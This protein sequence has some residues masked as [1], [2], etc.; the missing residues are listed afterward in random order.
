MNIPLLRSTFDVVRQDTET[1][2]RA[3]YGRLFAV[4]PQVSPLFKDTDFDSQ[5]KK[6][7]ASVAAV[8]SLVDK[9]DG[10]LDAVLDKLGVLHGEIGT[11]PEHY[12][13]VAASMLATLAE[14]LGDGWTPEAADTWSTALTVVSQ[15]MIDAQAAAA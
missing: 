13:M 11:L 1:F 12:P 9:Q 10:E 14:V 5:R 7:A 4:Y 6:L 3:F 8:V 15:K 2:T